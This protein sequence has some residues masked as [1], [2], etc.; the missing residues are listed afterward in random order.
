MADYSAMSD[1]ELDA[2]IAGKDVSKAP[3][4]QGSKVL[5]E[6]NEAVREKAE[7]LEPKPVAEE[8]EPSALKRGLAAAG[9]ALQEPFLQAGE[10]FELAFPGKT[11]EAEKATIQRIGQERGARKEA[12]RQ[13]TETTSG[14]FGGFVGQALPYVAG[15]TSAGGQA[16]LAGA[17]GFLGG[18]PEKPTGFG[19]E[20]AN[21]AFT[22]ATDAA[23]TG[24]VTKGLQGAVGMG[25]GAMGQY[26]SPAAAKAMEL[27][28]AARRL[29][30]PPTTIGQLDV[31][32]PK[33]LRAHPELAQEQAAA[34]ESRMAGQRQVPAPGGGME[35]QVVPG[36]RLDAG[37][38]EAVNVRKTQARGMYEDVDVFA[39]NQGLS[40]V[41]ANYT[42]NTLSSINSKLTPQGKAPTGNNLVFN[43]LDTYDP[44]A[45]MWLKQAGDPKTARSAGMSMTQYHDSRVA[46]GRAL[47]A[48]DRVPPANRT[49]DQI[50]AQKMLVELKDALDNDVGRWAKQNSGNEEAM[51]L[52]NRAKDFYA[53]V[54]APALNNPYARKA[55]SVTRGF[56]S[57]EAMYAA[58]VNPTNRSL[59]ERLAQTASPETADMLNVLQ[60]LPDVGAIAARGTAPASASASELGALVRAGVGHPGLSML[61]AAPGLRWLSSQRP[62]KWAYFGAPAPAAVA[63]PLGQY[64]AEAPKEKV[65][66]L[67]AK[68]R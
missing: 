56:Q 34:L 64:L 51:A 10:K 30:L 31:T 13:L 46:V 19:N 36:G 26:E 24:T 65:R 16:A 55:A 23:I 12:M 37:L 63:G 59:V 39:Q 42:V 1:E 60:N 47:N 15:G 44:D 48:L 4:G 49:A 29:G 9:G 40:N 53:K 57:P 33:T 58:T 21:S 25:R 66:G 54:A 45:F 62:A 27:D 35:T 50:D 7:R 17:L 5:T 8:I 6:R 38:K 61:E 18:G 28:A 43:L 67:A 52:Y 11:E 20:M 2:I 41:P 22:G 14:Q 3:P 68:R 32:A